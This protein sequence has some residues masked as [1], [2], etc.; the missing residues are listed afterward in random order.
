MAKASTTRFTVSLPD[1]LME[2]LDRLRSERGYG[3]RSEFVRDLLRGELVRE[4]WT[5]QRGET[6]GVVLLVYDHD[7]RLLS[8]KLTDIQHH[9][10]RDIAAALHIHLDEH[11]CLEVIALRGSARRIR[12][13]AD[14]LMS[15]KGV[16]YGKLVPATTGKGMQ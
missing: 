13:L 8:D 7:T 6:V 10:F 9:S 2:T 14:S 15:V 5:E 1:R 11:T 16:R 12:T 4:E 3:N